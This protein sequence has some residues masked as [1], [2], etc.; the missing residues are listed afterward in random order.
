[1]TFVSCRLG[2]TC[3]SGGHESS[4]LSRVV[5]EKHSRSR[6][7]RP[8]SGWEKKTPRQQQQQQY[9]GIRPVYVGNGQSVRSGLR[10]AGMRARQRGVGADT[11]EKIKSDNRN[12]KDNKNDDKQASP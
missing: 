1:M 11:R 3:K 8:C 6:I 10:V 5:D 12:H 4:I 2:F 9:M 7:L